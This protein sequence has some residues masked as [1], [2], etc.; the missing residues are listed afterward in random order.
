MA[1]GLVAILNNQQL[2][3]IEEAARE[4]EKTSDPYAH[5]I[6]KLTSHIETCWQAAHDAKQ[7]VE[8]EM[9]QDLRQR[10]GVYD[11]DKLAA[12]RE[13]GGSEIYMQVT[14]LKCRALE[15]WLRDILFPAGERPF[16]CGPTA[17]PDLSGDIRQT[18]VQ[19]VLS[20]AQQAIESGLYVTEREVYERAR[21]RADNA[22]A[23]IKSEAETRASRM[24]DSIDDLF[25]EGQW[26]EAMGDMLGDLVA[27]PY[28]CLKGPVIRKQRRLQWQQ[29]DDGSWQPQAED[30]LV[31]VWYSPSPLDI[32]PAPDSCGPQ[33]GYIFERIAIRHASLHRM[34]GVPG[35][36]EEAIRAVLEEYAHGYR[37]GQLAEQQ[38]MELENKRNWEMSPDAGLDMLEFHGSVKGQWLIDWGIEPERVP[39][40]DQHYEVTV[41]KIGRH[42]VRCVLNDDPM[43]RRPYEIASFDR[44]KGQFH[45]RGLPR[46]I[47]D[48]QDV[49]NATARALINNM[50]IASGPMGEVEMDRLAEGEDVTRLWP[51]RMVQTKS[52]ATTPAPAVRWHNISSHADELLKVYTY[53]SQ[54]AD[55]YSGVQSFDHGVSARSGAASTASG[56]SMLMNASGRQ[57]KRVIAAID[58]VIDGS[59]QRCHSHVMLYGDDPEVKG[60]VQVET[61]G[62]SQLMVREQQQ[63]RRAEFLQMTA[64]P[65]DMGIIGMEGRS[66][67]LREAVKSLDIPVDRVVPERDAIIAR[68]RQEAMAA[69]QAAQMQQGGMPAP[70]G[71]APDAAQFQQLP[72]PVS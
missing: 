54:L 57:V 28:G 46:I 17:E 66:E 31:P 32:Y 50:G 22:R 70:G 62:A 10:E 2:D 59:V 43:G 25:I 12:I 67:L 72:G 41:A 53:F 38:R 27:L 13:Q 6:C 58:K 33:D 26:Y 20:E 71:P 7:S 9:L 44:I 64:N 69:A 21:E 5:L 19:Q 47:R 48:V 60:D 37:I 55:T 14:N 45:G 52:S 3:E 16:Y 65:I 8:R 24:E 4:A 18:I 63:M 35:Y 36:K 56:L 1:Y 39:D 40:P 42:V 49:C 30:E 51:W 68:I 23:R 34:I 11:P 15:S 29:Q 61:R